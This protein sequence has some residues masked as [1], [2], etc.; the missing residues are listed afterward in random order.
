VIKMALFGFLKHKKVIQEVTAKTEG[1]PDVKVLP[2]HEIETPKNGNLEIKLEG[3]VRTV[4]KVEHEV[5]R[6]DKTLKFVY[7]S[8]YDSQ[9]TK[10]GM[11][12][13][14]SQGGLLGSWAY[15]WALT[16]RNNQKSWY[17]T[18][19]R[20]YGPETNPLW[21]AEFNEGGI[22]LK[23]RA[24]DPDYAFDV[25]TKTIIGATDYLVD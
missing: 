2:E 8:S 23:A 3:S 1:L 11:C 4:P 22:L 12:K 24:L 16:E 13:Y 9:G 5:V 7:R 19:V 6:S 18:R 14:D 15:E 25:D 21:E 17:Q 10:T 20:Y